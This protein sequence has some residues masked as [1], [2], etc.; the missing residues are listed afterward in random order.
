M[1]GKGNIGLGG[2]GGWGGEGV[3]LIGFN[4]KFA[5]IVKMFGNSSP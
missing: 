3:F 2:V 4:S 5:A 1:I